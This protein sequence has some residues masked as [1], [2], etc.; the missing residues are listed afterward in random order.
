MREY[1]AVFNGEEGRVACRD[2]LTDDGYVTFINEAGTREIV[3]HRGDPDLVIL[4]E[5]SLSD[6]WGQWTTDRMCERNMPKA[7]VPLVHY[8]VKIDGS[9][10]DTQLCLELGTFGTD[11]VTMVTCRDCQALLQLMPRRGL[12]AAAGC[13]DLRGERPE[14]AVRRIRGGR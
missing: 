5:K 10:L 6:A 13:L 14:D 3:L 12:D 11:D 7:H 2:G 4:G 9:R 1:Y 8:R